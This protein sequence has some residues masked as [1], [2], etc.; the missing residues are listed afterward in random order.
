MMYNRYYVFSYLF[1]FAIYFQ[2]PYIIFEG[3]QEYIVSQGQI[4]PKNVV[5]IELECFKNNFEISVENGIK[6]KPFV[7]N[8]MRNGIKFDEKRYAEFNKFIKRSNTVYI[9]NPLCI[10]EK[11]F[12]IFVKGSFVKL[13][14][15]EKDDDFTRQFTFDF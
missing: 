1:I 9:S 13:E 14:D 12:S 6:T 3:G 10:N 11:S 4:S 5:S 7:K 2:S 8:L 15:D